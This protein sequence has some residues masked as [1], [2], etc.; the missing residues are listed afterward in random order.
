[1]TL[2]AK[3]TVDEYVQGI[4]A[5]DIAVLSRAITLVESRRESDKSMAY[6]VIERVLP[7]TER[8]YRIG[9]SGSPGVGKS[10]FI[11]AIGQFIAQKHKLAVLTIDPSSHLSKGSILGDKTRME[12]L[13][14]NPNVYIRSTASGNA[15]GGIAENTY[16]AMLLCEA[17]GYDIILIETVGVGQ[18]EYIIKSLV[19]CF[20]LLILGNSG[21]ELQ[22]IKRGIMEVADILVI[23]KADEA[24]RR[25]ALQSQKAYQSA[26][27]WMNHSHPHWKVP[28]KICSAYENY[29]I[30]N[31]WDTI[32]HF[33]NTIT[34]SHPNL[35][36][37][38]TQNKHKLF[39]QELHHLWINMLHNIPELAIQLQE[40]EK[41]LLENKVTIF[42]AIKK[43]GEYIKY[44]FENQ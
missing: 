18:S 37:I 44:F 20:L 8:S 28:V 4:L 41:N 26:L 1:M 19:D 43:V 25:L 12:K 17:A 39:K 38:R 14:L 23:T 21:D 30:Q 33:F 10:T 35:Q 36:E 27:Q 3:L 6:K 7:Y 13:A 16:E 9:V 22:G 32:L 42:Q 31:V 29:Q 40:Q 5:S 11:E 2:R 15:F 24:V 34:G